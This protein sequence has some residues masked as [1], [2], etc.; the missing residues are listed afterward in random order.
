MRSYK[1]VLCT[2]VHCAVIISGLSC[3]IVDI[4][5]LGVA[6]KE[7]TNCRSFF[8]DRRSCQHGGIIALFKR[9]LTRGGITGR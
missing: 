7:V 1:T 8:V 2:K 3:Y 9:L 5:I 4:S 6:A